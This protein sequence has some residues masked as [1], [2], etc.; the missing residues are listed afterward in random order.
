MNW[1]KTAQSGKSRHT[2]SAKPQRTATQS[3][4]FQNVLQQKTALDQPKSLT[5]P[6]SLIGR[7][8]QWNAEHGSSGEKSQHIAGHNSRAASHSHKATSANQFSLGK[9]RPFIPKK[10]ESFK[11][12]ILEKA[13]KYDVNP[14]L[15]AGIIKQ[16]SN[17]NHRAVSH[18][19]AMGLM[20]LMPGTAKDMGV[21]D[22]FDPVQN[23]DGGVKYISQ[24]LKRYN[25]NVSLALAAYN[26]GPG[27]V[28]KYN[29]VPPYKETQNYVKVVAK[30]TIGIQ[31]AGAFNASASH[32]FA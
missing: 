31:M 28:D 1:I 8:L 30:H 21:K 11:D 13:K 4:D 5:V 29:G 2:T 12:I 32:R 15:V 19:G 10:F 26:A 3:S 25:G 18:C 27:A 6:N 9:V 17:F 23:I 14:H 22:P 20:Q 7:Q 16:E 24:M